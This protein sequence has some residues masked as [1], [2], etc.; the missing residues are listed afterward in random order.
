[1]EGRVPPR[2]LTGCWPEMNDGSKPGRP[3]HSGTQKAPQNGLVLPPIASLPASERIQFT[4]SRRL[5]R[6]PRS[7]M[8]CQGRHDDKSRHADADGQR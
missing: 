1:M 6:F 3:G 4:A 5:H 2:P 8:K 7:P